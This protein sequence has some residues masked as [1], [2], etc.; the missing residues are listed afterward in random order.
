[1][2]YGNDASRGRAG[3]ANRA[4]P[5]PELTGF[6]SRLSTSFSQ[7]RV[8]AVALGIAA[9]CAII[10]IVL[11]GLRRRRA[12]ARGS[13]RFVFRW[14][15]MPLTVTG[16]DNLPPGPCV[17]VANH[18]SYLDGVVMMAAV[19]PRFTF[20]I[21]GEMSKTPLIGRLLRRLG[22]AFVSRSDPKAAAGAGA[23][24][25][26]AAREGNAIG[27]FPE[28]TFK[29]EAGLRPFRLGAFVAAARGGLPVIPAA[30][31]GTR[32]I[33]PAGQLC[34]RSGPIRVVLMQKIE[35]RG[36]ERKHAECLR[37]EARTAILAR[38]DEADASNSEG[39]ASAAPFRQ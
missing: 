8:A 3:H 16:I 26:R 4:G 23:R 38:C 28:G 17:L 21:K 14:P 12:F 7:A 9:P 29:R 25:V 33:Y 20:L 11:P 39:A 13:S 6:V 31:T 34:P 5:G 35:A 15:G 36:A 37:K 19:P 18:S 1:V 22:M 30:I 32:E 2:G 10:S 24:L 27:V